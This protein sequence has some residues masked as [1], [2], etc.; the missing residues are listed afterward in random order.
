M[1]AAWDDA[2]VLEPMPPWPQRSLSDGLPQ[3][4]QQ[5][6]TKGYAHTLVCSRAE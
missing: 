2:E 1:S 6:E 3:M 4:A 5:P